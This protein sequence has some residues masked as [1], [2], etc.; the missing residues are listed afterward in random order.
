[1]EKRNIFEGLVESDFVNF[2]EKEMHRILV[3]MDKV[4]LEGKETKVVNRDKFF[5]DS[6][7]HLSKLAYLIKEFNDGKITVKKGL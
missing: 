3:A 2:Y 4:L 5:V 7:D 6:T 1:M